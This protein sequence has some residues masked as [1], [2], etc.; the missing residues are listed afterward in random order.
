MDNRIEQSTAQSPKVYVHVDEFGVM[1]VGASR[2]ML[3]SIVASFERG[4]SA[5]TIQQQYPAL[6][7][8]EVY[9]AITWC[10]AHTDEVAQYVRRQQTVWEQWRTQ[11]A[12]RPSPVIQRL[13]ALQTRKT[14]GSS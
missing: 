8:E 4:Y 12:A 6:S 11:T 14:Q 10:L 9:G 3:D 13:R 7:L 5:E 1:R 2:V